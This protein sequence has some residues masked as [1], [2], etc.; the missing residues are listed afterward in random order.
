MSEMVCPHCQSEDFGSA[1]VPRGVVAV[2]PC[3]KCS[4]LV[5]RFRNKAIALN[6]DVLYNGSRED[7]KMHLAEVIEEFMEEGILSIDMLQSPQFNQGE[8]VEEVDDSMDA[9]ELKPISDR[10]LKRFIDIDLD[11]LDNVDYFRKNFE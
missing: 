1:K 9:E 11:R 5:V 6:K 7:R 10:E 4:E 2:M 8:V 3:P